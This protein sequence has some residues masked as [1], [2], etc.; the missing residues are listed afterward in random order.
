MWLRSDDFSDG[1]PIPGGNAFNVID[2]EQHARFGGNKN[3]HL[4][5]GDV[6]EGVDSFALLVIDVDVPTSPEDVNQEGREVPP[7][8]PRTDFTHWVLVD[9]DAATRS[10]ER[11]AFSDGVT[12]KGESGRSNRP[13]EGVNDYTGWFA[14]DPEMG[15]TYK[16]YDGPCP[17]W[18]DS[19]I[20]HYLFTLYALDV[21]S[22]GLNGD[23]TAGDVEEAMK[24]HIIDSARLTGTYTLNPRLAG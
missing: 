17:P 5:W 1:K 14:G 16:G 22:L 7:D 15:G 6:P 24:G 13:S 9:I 12:P 11:S 10:V 21:D 19:L 3:P 8:L 23:F 18:N 2:S 4:E 20:H